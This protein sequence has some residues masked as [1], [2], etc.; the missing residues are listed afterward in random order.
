MTF[1]LV[2]PRGHP[3]ACLAVQS[4]STFHVECDRISSVVLLLSCDSNSPVTWYITCK[5]VS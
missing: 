3:K 1:N 2:L 4:K 5:H